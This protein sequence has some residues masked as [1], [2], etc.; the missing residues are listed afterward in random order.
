[1]LWFDDTN[2]LEQY[3]FQSGINRHIGTDLSLGFEHRPLLND[4][5]ILTGGVSTLIPGAGF[6]DLYNPF[7]GNVNELFATFLQITATY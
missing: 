2:V 7:V 4:N 6:K 1:M 3:V 5:L